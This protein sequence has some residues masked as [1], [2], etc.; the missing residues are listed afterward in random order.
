M[1]VKQKAK[2]YLFQ[3]KAD[4]P[5][6][7]MHAVTASTESAGEL[8]WI[9]HEGSLEERFVVCDQYDTNPKS[10]NPDI[11]ELLWEGNVVWRVFADGVLSDD[12]KRFL[13]KNPEYSDKILPPKI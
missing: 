8:Y 1:A 10:R 7:T 6:M 5:A 3:V 9:L 11:Y 4:L 12:L 13:K 2:T